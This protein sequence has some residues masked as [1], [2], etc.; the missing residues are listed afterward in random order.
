MVV[1]CS[2]CEREG[3]RLLERVDIVRSSDG[4]ARRGQKKRKRERDLQANNAD[5]TIC[6]HAVYQESQLC[7]RS[8]R[9]RVNHTNFVVVCG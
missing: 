3:S 7:G 5:R 4:C 8:P 1:E 2:D 6:F 9:E